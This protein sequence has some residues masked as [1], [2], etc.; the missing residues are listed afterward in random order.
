[1][2]EIN[3]EASVEINE[4]DE[5]QIEGSV[6]GKVKVPLLGSG[7]LDGKTGKTTGTEKKTNNKIFFSVP[8]LAEA[9]GE[10]KETRI[11]YKKGQ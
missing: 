9:I 3:F 6:S 1:V 8:Y 7:E 2:R 5:I 4:N 10:I 11:E